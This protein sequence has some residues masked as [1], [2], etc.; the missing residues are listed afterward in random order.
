MLMA[1]NWIFLQLRRQ[2]SSSHIFVHLLRAIMNCQS[3]MKLAEL[4]HKSLLH[5]PSI[6][7]K[8]QL[9]RVGVAFS[10]L[11]LTPVLARVAS[12]GKIHNMRK[13]PCKVKLAELCYRSLP[14]HPPIR[15]KRQLARVGVA[16]SFLN[17]TPVLARVAS[18]RKMHNSRKA[19]CKERTNSWQRPGTRKF[20]K[21]AYEA[22]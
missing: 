17:L 7:G 19:P 2:K 4:C 3:R 5:H 6:R 10:F 8:R 18:H 14:H 15:R 1:L 22:P 13:T 9:A 21:E 20:L 11:N 12:L 16:F